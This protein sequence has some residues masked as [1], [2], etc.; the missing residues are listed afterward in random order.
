MFAPGLGVGEDPATGSAVS[1]LAG[2]VAARDARGDG[3]A[4]WVVEQGFEMGRPS[5][6]ELEVDL[7]AGR[8]AEVRVGGASVWVGEGEMEILSV[9]RPCPFAA[10]VRRAFREVE[11]TRALFDLRSTRALARRPR[12][13]LLGARPRPARVE[14]VRSRGR[15]PVAARAEHRPVVARRRARRSSSRRCRSATR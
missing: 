6:L 12:A 8:L 4:R 15:S 5:L 13:R 1:A 7:R 14:P 10:L 11:R 3:T 9:L 2:Y